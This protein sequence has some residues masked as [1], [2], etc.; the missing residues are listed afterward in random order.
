MRRHHGHWHSKIDRAKCAEIAST[1]LILFILSVPYIILNYIRFNYCYALIW[2]L[3]MISF[4]NASFRSPGLVQNEWYRNYPAMHQILKTE[5]KAQL[6]QYKKLDKP[7]THY[8]DDDDDEQ[9]P[10]KIEDDIALPSHFARPPRSHYCRELQSDILRMDHFCIWLNN[11]IGFANY[12]FFVLTLF[13]GLLL[14]VSTMYIIIWDIWMNESRV[15]WLD[16]SIYYLIFAFISITMALI[17]SIFTVIHL[18]MHC[19]KMSKNLTSIEYS[20]YRQVEATCRYYK[21]QFVHTH[22]YDLGILENIKRMIG[23]NM[24]L[25]L[26]PIAPRLKDDPYCCEVNKQNKAKINA[27]YEQIERKIVIC[28]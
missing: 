24:F 7:Y 18:T 21:L 22:E 13:Y 28:G 2:I 19:L 10:L 5:Y 16:F 8:N 12:K 20:M 25:W 17:F 14:C 23:D 6:K 1:V 11:C 4:A 26:I 3:L 27:L 15:S 9:K